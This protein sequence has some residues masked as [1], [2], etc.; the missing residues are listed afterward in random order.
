MLIGPVF[1]REATIAPRRDKTYVGRG[2]YGGF[3][4]LTISAAWLATTGTQRVED[5]GDFARFGAALF[6]LLAPLQAV[7]MLFFGAMLAAAAVGQEKD[8]KTLLLLL[9]TR[10]SNSEL[11]LGKLASALLQILTFW[12]VSA[13]IFLAVALLGGVSYAQIARVLVA[14]LFAMAAAG[15]L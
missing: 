14:T 13:P 12:F 11:V 8:R 2:V 3:L 15:S 1:A 9:L 6:G 5:V 7:V 10:L 4:L